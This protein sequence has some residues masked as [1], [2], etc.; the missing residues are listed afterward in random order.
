MAK[1][2]V[3]QAKFIKGVVEGKTKRQAAKDAGYSGSP[4]TLSVTASEVLKKPNVQ[5]ALHEEMAR[6]GIS[7]D[8]VVKPVADG[9]KAKKEI[10]NTPD[11]T[12][13]LAAVKIAAKW[14]G[15]EQQGET[16]TTY[17]FTQI[18]NEKASK[19]AD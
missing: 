11:H 17:N 14:M 6:Q 13:R 15:L 18:I 9:L 10:T 8:A 12:T 5:A 19:Y 4:E 7:I 3:K 2:T 16:N 1:T